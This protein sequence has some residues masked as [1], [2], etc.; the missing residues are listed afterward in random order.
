MTEAHRDR[1]DWLW[2]SQLVTLRTYRN[3]QKERT[4]HCDQ[5]FI[6]KDETTELKLEMTVSKQCKQF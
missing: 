2:M 5:P 1:Q 4:C 6:E 3:G